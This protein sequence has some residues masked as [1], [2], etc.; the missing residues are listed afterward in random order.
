MDMDITLIVKAS[1]SSVEDQTI[2]CEPSWTIRRLKGHLTEVYPGKP[3]LDEQKLIYSGQL[4]GDGIILKDVLRHYEGQKTHTVHLVFTPKNNRFQKDFSPASGGSSSSSNSAKNMSPKANGE[5][6]TVP[7]ANNSSTSRPAGSDVGT[8]GLRQRNVAGGQ[9]SGTAAAP[10]TA[11]PSTPATNNFMEHHLAMQNLMQQAY[12][13]YLNQYMNVISDQPNAQALYA[14]APT[15][16]PAATVAQQSILQ[17][18]TPAT[19]A[20]AT[21]PPIVAQTL[22][23]LA[24]YPYLPAMN[25]PMPPMAS[26]IPAPITSSGTIPTSSSTSQSP[27]TIPTGSPLSSA[28]TAGPSGGVSPPAGVAVAST[29]VASPPTGASTT[30]GTQAGPATAAAPQV[31]NANAANAAGGPAG[32]GAAAAPARRFPN[33]VVEEQE[34][35]DWLDIFFSLC[36]VGIL[37]TV[38]YLYSSPV[39]CLT[40]LF[41]GIALY[42]YQIGFFRN[43]DPMERARRIVVQE[44]NNAHGVRQNAALRA[45]VARQVAAAAAAGGPA[46]VPAQTEQPSAASE[47]ADQTDAPAKESAAAE[48][49]ESTVEGEAAAPLV[50]AAVPAEQEPSNAVPEANRVNLN[51]VAGFLR[52]L[53][54]SFFTSIIPDTPAA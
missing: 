38:V 18:A 19:T 35:R 51:D 4:L 13:Q 37:M 8:D 15:N 7:A 49:P 12:M 47:T 44:I 31:E 3:S 41:I 20:A 16:L 34:N 23:N 40:V 50:E 28:S 1:N 5:G 14:S 27:A 52:T 39:R 10:V 2:K 9:T 54:L 30:D 22:P 11:C 21:A 48:Q 42:L 29:S 24:Y 43:N 53:V 46:P 33:I 26:S 32:A 45:R 25:S 6:T 36:R 17:T